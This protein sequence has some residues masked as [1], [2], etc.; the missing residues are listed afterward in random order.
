MAR[1]LNLLFL[2]QTFV[3]FL[4]L[5][6]VSIG[7]ATAWAI[8]LLQEPRDRKGPGFNLKEL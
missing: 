5:T 7:F 3:A 2:Y 1:N 8:F 4:A 6:F